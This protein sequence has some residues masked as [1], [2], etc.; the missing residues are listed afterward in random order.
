MDFYQKFTFF[1]LGNS[2]K[3]KKGFGTDAQ[4]PSVT[5]RLRLS[6][7]SSNVEQLSAFVVATVRA[8]PVW[9]HHLMA[10]ATFHQFRNP[11]GVVGAAAVA[12]TFAQFTFW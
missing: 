11:D 12:A 7:S 3:N 6:V 5:A 4:I 10:V 8:N 9:Q 1:A 2:C